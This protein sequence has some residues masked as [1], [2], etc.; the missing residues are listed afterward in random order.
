MKIKVNVSLSRYSSNVAPY[1]GFSLTVEDD[2]SQTRFI[3]VTIRPDQIA[4]LISNRQIEAEAVVR[5]LDKVGKFCEKRV[6]QIAP[7][8][9]YDR[10]EQSRQIYNRCR[11]LGLLKDGWELSDDG[12]GRRQDGKMWQVTLHR[13][14]DRPNS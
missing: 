8:D 10:K 6:E 12:T 4:D 7:P 9:S 1:D 13:F 14:V 3:D 11:D 5:H 2:T